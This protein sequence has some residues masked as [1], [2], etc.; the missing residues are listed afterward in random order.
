MII[1]NNVAL[2]KAISS[3]FIII[4]CLINCYFK[5]KK[6]YLQAIIV[7]LVNNILLN[8]QGYLRDKDVFFSIFGS[9]PSFIISDK[10]SRN[11]LFLHPNF[12]NTGI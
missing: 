7:E 4:C 5:A 10:N 11:A 2:V 1:N 8:L 9:S 3:S 6:P 12:S